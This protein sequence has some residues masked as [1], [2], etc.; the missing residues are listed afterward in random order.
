MPTLRSAAMIS[1]KGVLD[2]GRPIDLETERF[3]LRSLK[4]VD[5]SERWLSWAKDP[6]V[7]HPANAPVRH[8]T[9]Q[10]LAK[11]IAGHDNYTRYLIGVFDKASGLHIG[12]FF[13]DVDRA[14]DTAT[15]NV[16]IGEKSFWG[17]R[18]VNEARAALIDY[19]FDKL[20]MA[21]ICGGPL[22]RNFPMIFNY[23]A[24]GW[25]YEGTLRGHFK[26]VVDGSRLDQLRFR[27]L[28]HEWR[29]VRDKARGK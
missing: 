8:M 5:A 7:V 25:I 11:H 9:R 15:F 14:H 28:P 17:K 6:E 21:K 24:Q 22:A 18:V 1:A 16:M 10:E 12:F 20:G 3:R 13:I 4:P 23:K 19:F 2:P 29:A 27:F 26:S